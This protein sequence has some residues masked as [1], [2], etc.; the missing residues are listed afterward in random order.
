[1]TLQERAAAFARAYADCPA[2]WPWLAEED[3]RV[4][5]YAVWVVGNDYR[6]KTAFYGAYPP[7]F[8]DRLM[9]LFPD[10]TADDVLHVFSG[11]LPPG[12]YTRVDIN[13][14]LKPDVVGSVYDVAKLFP[15]RRFRLQIA[16]PP[17]SDD[18]AENYGTIMVDRYTVTQAL[19]TVA[20]VGGF[21]AWLD[22]VW[23]MHTKTQWVTVGRIYLQRSTNHRVRLLTLFERVAA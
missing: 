16:D 15:E 8:L 6:N 22:C 7:R 5:L 13:P 20:P 12:E 23:P 18:D 11:S 19:A 3:G 2:A 1:M 21:L 4:V 14:M 17:Y 9:A 10:V